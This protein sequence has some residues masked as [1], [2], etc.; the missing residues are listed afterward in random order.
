M[1]RKFST[2]EVEVLWDLYKESGSRSVAVKE[3]LGLSIF[4]GRSRDTLLQKL[5]DL[6]RDDELGVRAKQQWRQEEID[7]LMDIYYE[8]GN[9]ARAARIFSE[10]NPSRSF[11][12]AQVRLCVECKKEGARETS[13][14]Q[15]RKI[16]VGEHNIS[17]GKRIFRELDQIEASKTAKRSDRVDGDAGLQ[18][19]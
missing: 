14:H 12:A 1:R 11:S 4:Q 8:V 16:D 15:W 9:Q 3:A 6:K 10:R 17:I 13:E 18:S 19:I 7:E 5:D 2:A